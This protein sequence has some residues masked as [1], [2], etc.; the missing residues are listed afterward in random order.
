MKRKDSHI[1]ILLYI[2]LWLV[3][4][5]APLLAEYLQLLSGYDEAME[6]HHVTFLWREL[7]PLMAAFV[8]H[9]WLLAPILVYR[10]HRIPYMLCTLS[11][12][13]LFIVYNC[14]TRPTEPRKPWTEMHEGEMPPQPHDGMPFEADH[15][16]FDH[17]HNGGP[18]GREGDVRP[19]L[20]FGQHDV[21][22]TVLLLLLLSMNLGTKFYFK[23]RHDARQLELLEFERMQQQLSYLRYQINPHFLMNTLNN[24]HAL[25]DIDPEQAQESIVELSRLLRYV[26]YEADHELVA[27]Q[28][29][30]DFLQHF[31]ELMRIRFTDNV[32]VRF[33]VQ[34]EQP[35]AQVP[36]LLLAAFVENAFKHGMSYQQA[37][38]V[39][40][41]IEASATRL[42]FSCQNSKKPTVTADEA[43]TGGVG[44]RNARK[45]LELLFPD[46]Y[47]LKIDDSADAYSVTLD[48]PL[49][50]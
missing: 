39:H 47:L 11:V 49:K 42:H 33:D 20:L 17:H 21:L 27:L 16:P 9:N 22:T 13:A 38:F 30:V 26:L 36:P 29:E 45:R 44:L 8:L 23:H 4:A 3:V 5:A 14:N 1:E 7:L 10:Q 40:I 32:D 50:N 43:V 35:T 25:I 37:S 34:M 41:D 24:I 15:P 6:W 18:H 19:P 46:D 48:I 28:R 2:V 31:V 12:V